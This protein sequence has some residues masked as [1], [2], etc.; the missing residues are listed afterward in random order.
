MFYE[1]A[2]GSGE[3]DW[4]QK[5]ERREEKA[6]NFFKKVHVRGDGGRGARRRKKWRHLGREAGVGGGSSRGLCPRDLDAL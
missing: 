4:E 1:D 6:R 3:R 5:V 2:R